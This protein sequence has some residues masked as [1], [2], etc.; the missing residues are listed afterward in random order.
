MSKFQ[1]ISIDG[2]EKL[3]KESD[4][5]VLDYRDVNAYRAGHVENA[6]HVHEDLMKNLVKKGDKEQNVIVYCY[7]GHSS[8]HVAEMLS[9]FGFKHVFSVD[10]GF[11]AWKSRLGH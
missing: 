4:C 3:L 9:G 8:Q 7:H 1:C 2:A 11:E 5:L 10:G 6:L